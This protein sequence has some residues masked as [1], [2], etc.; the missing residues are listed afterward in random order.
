MGHNNL[1]IT[2]WLRFSNSHFTLHTKQFNVW[3]QCKHSSLREKW[4]SSQGTSGKP[5]FSLENQWVY[6]AYLQKFGWP[7]SFSTGKSLPSVDGGFLSLHKRSSFQ[8]TT[9]PIYSL[10]TPVKHLGQNWIQ[11]PGRASWILKHGSDD[12]PH[13]LPS[14]RECQLSTS[15]AMLDP[16]QQAQLIWWRW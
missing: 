9:P 8:L 12:T 3:L 16:C 7:Q 4:R 10:K 11:I 1:F 6:L 14:M 5:K 2:I 15:P 13:T